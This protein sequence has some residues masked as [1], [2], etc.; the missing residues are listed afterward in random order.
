MAVQ[1]DFQF[2]SAGHAETPEEERSSV[3]ILQVLEE[4][5][6]ELAG[7]ARL[8]AVQPKLLGLDHTRAA[9]SVGPETGEA[10][11]GGIEDIVP[12]AACDTIGVAKLVKYL[13]GLGV[14]GLLPHGRDEMVVD[15]HAIGTGAIHRVGQR[16]A[17]GMAQRDP[18]EPVA[19]PVAGPREQA[20][21]EH[22]RCVPRQCRPF[23]VGQIVVGVH[24]IL[25]ADVVEQTFMNPARNVCAIQSNKVQYKRVEPDDGAT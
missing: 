25:G 5:E 12:F 6:T 24:R 20:G 11:V 22:A 21:V 1:T 13:H 19:G 8:A 23:R 4:L 2:I 7:S 10:G 17:G 18:A 3:R 14:E 9:L 16:P 15:R